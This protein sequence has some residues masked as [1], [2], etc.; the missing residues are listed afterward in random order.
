MKPLTITT[1]LLGFAGLISCGAK[2]SS[3]KDSA[4]EAIKNFDAPS[5]VAEGAELAAEAAPSEAGAL[6][7]P[8]ESYA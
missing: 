6:H 4:V 5:D 8:E 3:E 1:L 7:L 2:E